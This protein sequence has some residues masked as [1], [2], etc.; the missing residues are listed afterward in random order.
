MLGGTAA[1]LADWQADGP[2]GRTG[3]DF[4]KASPVGLLII[5]LLLLGTVFLIRSMNRHLRK[6]PKSFER[7]NPE[8]DHPAGQRA[9]AGGRAPET[10]GASGGNHVRDE[11]DGSSREPDG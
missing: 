4:G 8:P 2:P 5:V 10:P 1:V 7:E 11:Q 9:A 3:P 6:I